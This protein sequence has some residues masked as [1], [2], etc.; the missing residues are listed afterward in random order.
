M[1]TIPSIS[2][3]RYITIQ[4]ILNRIKDDSFTYKEVRVVGRCKSFNAE[5]H[6]VELEDL[7]AEGAILNVNAFQVKGKIIEEGTNYEFMGEIKQSDDG[8]EQVF[9]EA[10]ILKKTTGFN[11]KVY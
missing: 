8:S 10:R 6:I 4:Q 1:S 11:K 5:T 2:T 7:F 3:C 9:L